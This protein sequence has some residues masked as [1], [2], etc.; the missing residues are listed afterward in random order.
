VDAIVMRALEKDPARRYA[1]IGAMR[2]ALREV[3]VVPE[4]RRSRALHVAGWVAMLLVGIGAAHGAASL[5]SRW[6][7]AEAAALDRLGTPT[8]VPSAVALAV[9][10]ALP[11]VSVQAPAAPGPS[12]GPTD[13]VL[14]SLDLPPLQE[15]K[16]IARA[17]PTDPRALEVWARAAL[18]AGDL[19]E[20]RR[21]AGAWALHDGRFEPRLWIAHALEASGRRSEARDVMAEWLESHPDAESARA[22]YDRLSSD[23]GARTVAHR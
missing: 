16:S 22:E 3:L 18:R 15:A 10:P 6:G 17:H 11:S 20:A 21:A 23:P 4:R 9:P 8:G 7:R 13:S 14:A 5:S 1:T 12:S 2:D 19:R